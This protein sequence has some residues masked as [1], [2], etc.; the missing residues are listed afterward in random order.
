MNISSGLMSSSTKEIKQ[1]LLN[2]NDEIL[3]F[4][5]GLTGFK[6]MPTSIYCCV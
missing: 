4:M 1:L 6:Q 2:M 5:L 3:I